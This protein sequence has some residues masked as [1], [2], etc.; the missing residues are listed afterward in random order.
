MSNLVESYVDNYS[1]NII[2]FCERSTEIEDYRVVGKRLLI[3]TFTVP[4]MDLIKTFKLSG[5]FH[6]FKNT[7][8]FKEGYTVWHDIPSKK[9][10]SSFGYG[11]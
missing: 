10:I 11:Y 2:Q 7:G 6:N 4:P 5:V 8:N 3:S 9:I 1:P